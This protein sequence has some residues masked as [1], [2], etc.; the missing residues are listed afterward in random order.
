MPPAPRLP[1]PLAHQRHYARHASNSSWPFRLLAEG[2][3]EWP[4]Y[5][6]GHGAK[7]EGVKLAAYTH[8]RLQGVGSF[9][10][11]KWVP[12]SGGSTSYSAATPTQEGA[13]PSSS[14]CTLPPPCACGCVSN[15]HKRLACD[16]YLESMF[17]AA[18]IYADPN[19]GTTTA[20]CGS[21]AAP[22]SK[23]A[24]AM[25]ACTAY[26]TVWLG[27]GKQVI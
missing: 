7:F 19:R 23:I 9:Y 21:W 1:T 14:T 22:C 13:G 8:R 4:Q 25:A 12:T 10:R 3:P 2:T 17:H 11:V 5:P 27:G 15:V 16:L 18:P 24:D 20:G 6:K 26:G